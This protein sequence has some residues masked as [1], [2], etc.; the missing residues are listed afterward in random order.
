MSEYGLQL[1]EKQ[2]AKFIYGVL[3]KPFHNYYDKADRRNGQKMNINEKIYDFVNAHLCSYP[4]RLAP[5][6]LQIRQPSW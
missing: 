4:Q 6:C 1:R 5:Q 3:E 2:K